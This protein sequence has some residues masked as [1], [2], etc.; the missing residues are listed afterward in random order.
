MPSD[1]APR[2]L[3]RQLRGR[4]DPRK[5]EGSVGFLE[6]NRLTGSTL[7]DDDDDDGDIFKGL[8]LENKVDLFT[9][10]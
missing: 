5:S 7:A 9:V 4:R 6:R 1:R 2:H 3:S 10:L 8:T